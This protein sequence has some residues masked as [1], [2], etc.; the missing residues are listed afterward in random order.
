MQREKQR[1]FAGSS[2]INLGII[3]S[4]LYCM[5]VSGAILS[6]P[7]RGG[8]L[9]LAGQ[10]L[11]TLFSLR[12]P[13]RNGMLGAHAGKAGFGLSLLLLALLIALTLMKPGF[14]DSMDFMRVSGLVLC[15]L[16]RP[17]VLRFALE[18]E[19]KNRSFPLGFL[20]HVVF[21]PVVL[22]I[23]LS[24]KL[25][26]AE[27]VIFTVGFA[28]CRVLE[29]FC[30]KRR[31]PRYG[32]FTDADKAELETIQ[33]AYAF[34]M[35]QYTVLAATAAMQATLVLGYTC[36]A[37]KADAP[38]PCL[39]IGLLCGCGA[40][41]AS[42]ALLRRPNAQKANPNSLKGLGL[43]VWL[44]GMIVF[45]LS[46][47]WDNAVI[48]S[49]SLAF[50][51]AGTAV[52]VRTL[53]AMEA[54][55]RRAGAFALG[56]EPGSA[57]ENVLQARREA[58]ALI[59]LTL[60]LIGL[61]LIDAFAASSAAFPSFL[62]LLSVPALLLVCAAI[63]LEICFPLTKV[64]LIKLCQYIRQQRQGIENVPLRN[65]LE[66]VVMQKSFRNYGI[67]LVELILRPFFYHKV[68]GTENVHLD[69]DIPCVLVCNHG[70][71]LGPVVCT[72]FVPYHPF[73]AWS[74]YE[75]MD[76]D[77]VIDRTMNGTFQNVKG[78]GRK[79]LQ[80]LMEHIGAPFLVWLL[81]SEYCI[82]VYHDNPR[83]LMQ[84]F[85]E[86]VTTMQAGDS[87]LVFPENA[88]T[89]PDHRYM[90]EGVSEFFTGFTMIGQMYYNK[91]GKCPLFV[92]MY[93]D[94]RRRVVTFGTPTRYDADAPVNEEKERLCAY[95]R[96]E[97]LSLAK[98]KDAS[99]SHPDAG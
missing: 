76:R 81:E 92:P 35:Y 79:L 7:F 37:A 72:L 89:S 1:D 34:Q 66:P 41:I 74:A 86:T 11:L 98:L 49:I 40:V 52:C 90:Q 96:N 93:A 38:L 19:K 83:K 13:I 65:Q 25:P 68:K 62:P 17:V 57:L 84:T 59:G 63:T 46:V 45:L 3:F 23:L 51:F 60:A 27:T 67:R 80:W 30:G 2:P 15:A 12:K 9:Y 16:F 33:K 4:F 56:R 95:L 58:A 88:A 31:Y 53:S 48:C 28:F 14:P 42:E 5:A 22:L 64:H 29:C 73:R 85:R 6:S 26:I 20:A 71:I 70:E 47:H 94:K 99:P 8:A 18:H 54:D 87:I 32:A 97:I 91:T 39:L 50:S 77:M 43:S 78:V 61:T 44:A 55:M 36:I 82:R 21:L 10:C 75:M 24:K 69:E